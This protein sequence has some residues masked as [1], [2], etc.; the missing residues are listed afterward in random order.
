MQDFG[1]KLRSIREDRD[2]SREK[3]AS[4]ID[5]STKQIERWENGTSETGILK[6]R[7]ICNH[8][9]ISANYLLGIKETHDRT[10]EEILER[11]RQ[12]KEIITKETV[13]EIIR[14]AEYQGHIK[15]DIE[16]LIQNIYEIDE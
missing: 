9:K 7:K 14:W 16:L 6:L 13:E 11:T 12:M 15:G 4:K 2:E 8:Y 10:K 1:K 5:S 3:L